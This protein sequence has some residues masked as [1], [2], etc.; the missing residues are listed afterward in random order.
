MSEVL[1]LKSRNRSRLF[2]GS[3]R[4]RK[5]SNHLEL[6]AATRTTTSTSATASSTAGPL[7]SPTSTPAAGKVTKVDEFPLLGALPP[8][9]EAL[10]TTMASKR[11]RAAAALALDVSVEIEAA[12]GTPGLT[13]ELRTSLGLSLLRHLR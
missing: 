7:A 8:R 4:E 6:E 9:I 11:R 2:L 3:P 5:T 10:G 12:D 1:Q 13:A